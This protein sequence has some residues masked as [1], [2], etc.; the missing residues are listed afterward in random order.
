MITVK[1]P[2]CG[3]NGAIAKTTKIAGPNGSLNWMDCGISSSNP[4][5]GG[6]SPPTVK[7]DE[8]VYMDLDTA[9]QN[10]SSPFQN[11]QP[12]LQTF[13]DVAGNTTV[14]GV[15]LQPILLASFAMQESSCNPKEQGGGGEVGMFQLSEDKCP[16]GKAS[17][18]CY[19][20]KNNTKIAA[21]YIASQIE[22]SGGN[23][24]AMVGEYNGWYLNMTYADA[25]AAA[26]G[27]CCRCQNNLDYLH[28]FFNGWMLNIDAY[29]AGLGYYFN[30]NS[31]GAS[32]ALGKRDTGLPTTLARVRRN[33]GWRF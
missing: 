31:C 28:Q 25:T 5:S 33:T 9:L 20:A 32:D 8:I 1:D 12:Y 18:A 7:L 22:A 4:S 19:D 24:F 29:S 14:N 21:A 10:S 16:G 30:L 15:A 17:D 6:W 26:T 2:K 13:K 23:L 27:N 11:C 3:S